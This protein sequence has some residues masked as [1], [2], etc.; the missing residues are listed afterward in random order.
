VLWIALIVNALMFVVELAAGHRAQSAS[1]LADAV[2]F[3]GDATNYAVSL[4]ALTLGAVWRSRTALLKGITMGLY[5]VVV[6]ARVGWGAIEGGVPHANTMGLIGLLALIANVAVA[7]LLFAYREGDAN[8]RSVW[9]CSRND[10]IGNVAVICAAFTVTLTS[11]QWPDLAVA[12]V[13]AVLAMTAG[14]S[15]IKQALNELAGSAIPL[16]DGAQGGHGS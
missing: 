5:G 2:D 16:R 9:L 14:R 4:F 15:V 12:L 1:L 8:M 11:S 3:L 13:M 7:V 6:L 10:A